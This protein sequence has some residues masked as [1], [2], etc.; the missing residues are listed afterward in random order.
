ME[1]GKRA[2]GISRRD[3]IRTS[4]LLP[5]ALEGVSLTAGS[6]QAAAQAAPVPG[7]GT[8]STPP[9]LVVPTGAGKVRGYRQDGIAIFKG[10]PY[11]AST[12]GSARFLPPRPPEPWKGTRSCLLYGAISPQVS[13]P[14]KSE[15]SF[16]Q[17]SP[18]SYQSEDC[19]V[20]NVWSSGLSGRGKPVMVWLHG[21]NFT[22][23]SGHELATT[24]GAGLARRGD[25]VVVSINH[26][27]G[28]LGYLDL[29]GIGASDR[30]APAV[31]AGMLDIVQ[32]LEW[33]R[34]N[35][36][37]FGGDPGNVTVFGQSG[38]GIKVTALNAMPSARGLF[39][40]AIVQ[41]GSAERLFTKEMTAPLAADLL[42]ELGLTP[43]TADK[44]IDLPAETLV[45]AGDKVTARFGAAGSA[46]IWKTVGWA[47]RPDGDVIPHQ[48][49]DPASLALFGNVPLMV[50]CCRHEVSPSLGDPAL[51]D[52]TMDQLKTQLAA[53]FRDPGALA[54]AFAAGNP[55]Q[56]PVALAGI[57]SA[58]GFNRPNAVAQARAKAR[59]G[60][61]PA[62]LYQFAFEPTVLDGRPRS[63]HCAE[64]PMAFYSLAH[65]PE[66]TGNDARAWTMA[67]RVSDAWIAFARTGNP[68]HP[69]IPHWPSASPTTAPTMVFNDV[70][71]V[72]Q[73]RDAAL[74]AMVKTQR[75]N[76]PAG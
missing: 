21:G 15:F 58:S 10:I 37:G 59:G 36:A 40:R 30:F 13:W 20:L 16:L 44:L 39:H 6:A 42:K 2:D 31:N 71:A 45:A 26:R 23:G 64:L 67:A 24:D 19:L 41:S 48:P 56:R 28:L 5:L 35:I 53:R 60:G 50:G 74:L 27:L 17:P 62:Y 18:Y 8:V 11:G 1:P 70:C 43:A 75:I 25:V 61:A 63:Y 55:G 46:D 12:A 76:A 66:A 3:I 38:G 47:P 9:D 33:V 57:I 68:N 51:E 54:E 73:D 49:Y 34:D 4:A 32:A 14:R 22:T 29:V 69:G 72:E 65:V 52:M 7:L